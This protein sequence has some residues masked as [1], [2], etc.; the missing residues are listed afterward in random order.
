MVKI[1]I[2]GGVFPRGDGF[3]NVDQTPNADIHFDLNQRPWSFVEPGTVDELY[4][5][6]CFEHLNDINDV[7]FQICHICKVG[8]KVEFRV[9]HPRSDLAM[10][11]DHK[12]VYSPLAAQ[13]LDVHFVAHFWKGR[14]PRRLKL[15]RSVYPEGVEYRAAIPLEECK[16]ECPQLV[17]GMTDVQIMKYIPGTCHEC[18]YHYTVIENEFA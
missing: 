18:A 7:L 8:A 14:G 12:H 4:S 9:P 11:W 5:S 1:D 3:I 2:G 6:H 15:N 16:R 17:Q 10:V 13:N